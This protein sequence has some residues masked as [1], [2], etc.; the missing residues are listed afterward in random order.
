MLY[1]ALIAVLKFTETIS[2]N[3]NI[4]KE[5]SPAQNA[6]SKLGKELYFAGIVPTKNSLGGKLA[7]KMLIGKAGKPKLMDM[8]I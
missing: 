8:S 3:T 6:V 2:V 4:V 7:K 1:T 5:R